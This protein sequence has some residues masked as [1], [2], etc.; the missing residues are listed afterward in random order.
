M[1]L[2]HVSTRLS[3]S[4]PRF[5]RGECHYL[6]ADVVSCITLKL[7]YNRAVRYGWV[8]AGHACNRDGWLY[9]ACPSL[10]HWQRYKNS[11]HRRD[12]PTHWRDWLREESAAAAERVKAAGR[13]RWQHV[14]V[15]L[16]SKWILPADT[17]SRVRELDRVRWV[18]RFVGFTGGTLTAH[19]ARAHTAQE[20]HDLDAGG[21]YH[22][23]CAGWCDP[24]LVMALHEAYGVVVRAYGADRMRPFQR[25]QYI[26]SHAALP[27]V[28]NP[29][30]MEGSTPRHALTYWGIVS[31][32]KMKL[33]PLE[34]QHYCPGCREGFPARSWHDLKL[35]DAP[36]P[37]EWGSLQGL[38]ARTFEPYGSWEAYQ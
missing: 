18:L 1:V 6:L 12:C 25:F 33:P 36:P 24:E 28:L 13:Q 15:S 7:R 11:C 29:A 4:I 35:L 38:P 2:S 26:L 10:K 21:H 16:G 32:N 31:Y 34:A 20:A 27:S 9:R 8:G 23:L 5:F 3:L 22:G 19:A 37:G 17:D 14:V 30:R